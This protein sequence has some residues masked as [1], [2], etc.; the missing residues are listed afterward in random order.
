MQPHHLPFATYHPL[1]R[2]HRDFIPISDISRLIMGVGG[3]TQESIESHTF[4][5]KY[6]RVS[7]YL[8]I[9]YW[10]ASFSDIHDFLTSKIKFQLKGRENKE[11]YI[12]KCTICLSEFEESENLRWVWHFKKSK[13]YNYLCFNY[14]KFLYILILKEK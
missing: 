7:F 4:P 2:D 3:A 8:F 6:K 13:I 1:R 9:L 5:Y 10:F 14:W 12:E 11:E